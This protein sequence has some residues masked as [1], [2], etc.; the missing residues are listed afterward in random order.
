MSL[1]GDLEELTR[2][3]QTIAERAKGLPWAGERAWTPRTHLSTINGLP[4]ID[5]HDLSVRLAREA[6]DQAL[7]ADLEC[8]GFVVVTGRGR[9][10]GG[11]SKLRT[12]VLAEL[13]IRQQR[14]ELVARPL[15]PAR[16]EVIVSEERVRAARPGMGLLF[17]LFAALLLAAVV[18]TVVNR[19]G[20]Q[21]P[22]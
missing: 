1:H 19:M 15:G 22:W 10:T 17:W 2:R 4:G 6:I 21:K 5:L 12:A 3:L 8:G 16:I 11:H 9:H 7:E 18:A 20:L 14:E 13:E